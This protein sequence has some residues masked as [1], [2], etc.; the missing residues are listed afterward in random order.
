MHLF[1]FKLL[2]FLGSISFILK[3]PLITSDIQSALYFSFTTLINSFT[4]VNAAVKWGGFPDL[5][6]QHT[7]LTEH[8]VFSIPREVHFVFVPEYLWLKNT[9][10]YF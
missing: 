8:A 4:G 2:L 7:L 6:R 5:Q 10:G 9:E 1:F 3:I